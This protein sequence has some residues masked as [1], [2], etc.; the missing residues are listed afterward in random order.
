[1]FASRPH[2]RGAGFTLI[3]VLVTVVILSVGIVAIL[4][5]FQASLVALGAAQ[6]SLRGTLLAREKMG[7]VEL[8]CLARKS[9]PPSSRETF[10]AG[11]YRGFRRVCDVEGVESAGGKQ[12]AMALYRV[13]VSVSKGSG[14]SRA[15]TTYVGVPT[16]TR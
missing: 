5:A 10:D 11:L 15:V 12:Q 6:D 7:D 2:A 8:Q 9:G 13:T 3:E 14:P 4:E 1:M 16:Q